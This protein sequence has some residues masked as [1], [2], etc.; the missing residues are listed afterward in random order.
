[1]TAIAPA[2]DIA[3]V[4]AMWATGIA[5]IVWTWTRGDRRP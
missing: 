1:M 3:I 5:I 4:A 2:S